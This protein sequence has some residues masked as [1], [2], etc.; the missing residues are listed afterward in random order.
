MTDDLISSSV[1]KPLAV[2]LSFELEQPANTAVT[3]NTAR[4]AEMIF[5]ILFIII[6]PL[7]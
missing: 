2:E 4:I 5:V 3:T 1:L 6:S 7:S